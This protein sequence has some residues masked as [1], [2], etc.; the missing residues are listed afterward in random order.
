M[1]FNNEQNSLQETVPWRIVIAGDWHGNKY[2]AKKSVQIAHRM[3]ADFILHVGD[4]GYN[5]E[6]AS[7]DGYIFNKPLQKELDKYD[8]NLVWID[9]NHDNHNWLRSLPKREDGFVQTGSGGRVFWAPRG[10]RWTWGEVKFGAL[11]GAYSINFKYLKE[12]YSIFA[13]LEDVKEEDLTILGKDKLDVLLTHEIAEGTP[14]KK[15]F[16]M[17]DEREIIT[18]ET[19]N[20]ILRAVNNT[21]P[22][23]V[24]SGHWHQRVDHTINRNDGGVTY[25]HVLDKENKVGN[26][27]AYDIFDNEI[28]DSIAYNESFR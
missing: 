4:L 23:H 18:A 25:Q 16:N 17:S 19:R 12:G 21:R 27:V 2:W 3:G 26:L 7:K 10:L 11:G 5:F 8:I 14:V 6:N 28:I 1:K 9:G 22:E 20:K 13:N 15:L 24:F